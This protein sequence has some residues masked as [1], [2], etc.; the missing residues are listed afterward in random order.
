MPMMNDFIGMYDVGKSLKRPPEPFTSTRMIPFGSVGLNRER[1]VYGDEATVGFLDS[2]RIGWG[3]TAP[4]SWDSLQAGWQWK[5]YLVNRML[6]VTDASGKKTI[7]Q[8]STWSD[9]LIS[10]EVLESHQ[11][12]YVLNA[13][14]EPDPFLI[15]SRPIGLFL[16]FLSG[17]LWG[18]NG[19][20]DG[21]GDYHYIQKVRT[22]W[23]VASESGSL[24]VITFTLQEKEQSVIFAHITSELQAAGIYPLDLVDG[25]EDIVAKYEMTDRK[26][27]IFMLGTYLFW[28]YAT[29]SLFLNDDYE[30]GPCYEPWMLWQMW[31][32]IQKY[33][34]ADIPGKI[35]DISPHW[36][37]T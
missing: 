31:K 14:D 8:A 13:G 27:N 34:F 29:T 32:W 23:L 30:S 18:L 33:R 17:F 22:F 2:L 25:S 37:D 4:S 16:S 21:G 10:L 36:G 15:V 20:S 11:F 6:V 5:W 28:A 24:P 9:L 19:S 35:F 26:G 12:L 1:Y 7:R 3:D